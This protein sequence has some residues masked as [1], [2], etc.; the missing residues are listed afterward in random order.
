MQTVSKLI[1]ALLS[2]LPVRLASAAARDHLGYSCTG[3]APICGCRPE[4]LVRW[5]AAIGF[6]KAH[7]SCVLGRRH[8]H[9]PLNQMRGAVRNSLSGLHGGAEGDADQ[10]SSWW[11]LGS[12]QVLFPHLPC[13]S[14]THMRLLHEVTTALGP[15]LQFLSMLV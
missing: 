14:Q 15:R 5:H 2:M 11:P 10:H 8:A 7:S 3:R 1:L 9:G 4:G 6:R 12:T 13:N